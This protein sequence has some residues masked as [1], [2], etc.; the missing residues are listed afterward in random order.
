MKFSARKNFLTG[1]IK[2]IQSKE[3]RIFQ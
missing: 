3:E 2:K 1:K